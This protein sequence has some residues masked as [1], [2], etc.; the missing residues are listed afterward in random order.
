MY[1]IVLYETGRKIRPGRQIKN[2]FTRKEARAWLARERAKY[3]KKE[4][5]KDF[6]EGPG[7]VKIVKVPETKR[8]VSSIWG[9]G[10]LWV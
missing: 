6:L 2:F 4:H 8:K 7:G 1:K 3:T 10:S 5:K 9:S